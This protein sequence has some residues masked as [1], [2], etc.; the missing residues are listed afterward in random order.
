MVNTEFCLVFVACFAVSWGLTILAGKL[1]VWLKMMDEPNKDRKI[2]K[3]PTPLGGG[4]AIFAVFFLFVFL[5]QEYLTAGQLEMKHWLGFFIGASFLMIGGSLDDKFDLS[6]G[7]QIIWPL[8]AVASVIIGG[9]EIEK[10]TNPLGGYIYLDQFFLSEILIIVWLMVMMYT[11]KLL[12]GVDGLVSGLGAI[13]GIII[14]LFTITTQYFQPDIALASLAFASACLGFLVMN[15]HP[16][17]IF[18]GEGGSLLIGFILGVLAIISGGKI[19]IALLVLGIPIMDVAWIIIRRLAKGKNPFRFADKKHLHYRLLDLGLS[20]RKTVLV[21]YIFAAFFGLAGL[22]LQSI[23]KVLAVS[24]LMIIMLGI[25]VF[26][27]RLDKEK[28]G[29]E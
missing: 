12:D 20:P 13:G 2:H 1:A 9:V 24:A 3:E 10:V 8:L 7:K 25:I 17:K 11:T 4:I 16:A 27:T 29:H 22:F 26:F 21:F 15:W 6:P 28:T 23:G 5:F 19:A 14:F 18:L